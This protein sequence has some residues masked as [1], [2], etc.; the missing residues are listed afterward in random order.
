[1]TQDANRKLFEESGEQKRK[2]ADE[3]NEGEE[4][5]QWQELTEVTNYTSLSIARR[6]VVPESKKLEIAG[7][8][9]CVERMSQS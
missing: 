3:T 6:G 4:G 7:M 9:D 5:R 1:M 2:R 8:D